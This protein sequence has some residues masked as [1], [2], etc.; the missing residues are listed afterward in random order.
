METIKLNSKELATDE[1]VI[2]DLLEI[3]VFSVDEMT[4]VAAKSAQEAF[5]YCTKEMGFDIELVD[6]E[7]CDIDKEGMWWVVDNNPIELIETAYKY[8]CG[9]YKEFG[10]L[11]TWEGEPAVFIPFR[12]AI[13]M[14]EETFPCIIATCLS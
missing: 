1:T 4:W 10:E 12:E 8:N 14:T 2:V 11:S 13:K 6:V 3:T 7:E 5:D 9:G